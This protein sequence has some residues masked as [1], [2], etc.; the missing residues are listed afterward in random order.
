MVE[1]LLIS[2]NW[3]RDMD[4]SWTPRVCRITAF[5][6]WVL[7]KYFCMLLSGFGGLWCGVRPAA[8]GLRP[9]TIEYNSSRVHLYCL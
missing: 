1:I 2:A 7:G 8:F 4:T 6:T 3:D 9:T 5:V